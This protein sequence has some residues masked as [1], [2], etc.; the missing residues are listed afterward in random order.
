MNY[1][2]RVSEQIFCSSST[3]NGPKMP[4]AG[5]HLCESGIK[6]STA[7]KTSYTFK[8]VNQGLHRLKENLFQ[9]K[10][11]YLIICSWFS[12]KPT[13]LCLPKSVFGANSSYFLTKFECFDWN[14]M[15][16]F[17]MLIFSIFHKRSYQ[18][19]KLQNAIIFERNEFWPSVK[20]L[21]FPAWRSLK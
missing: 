5:Q 17:K 7:F 20:S 16:Y 15:K 10:T 21:C 1:C 12:K 11:L 19:G 9:G 6:Y 14:G 4:K 8:Q 18:N 2:F 3:K 13:L